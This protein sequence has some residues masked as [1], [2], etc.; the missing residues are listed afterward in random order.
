MATAR[1][2]AADVNWLALIRLLRLR[3]Q[4]GE[5]WPAIWAALIGDGTTALG[6]LAADAGDQPATLMALLALGLGCAGSNALAVAGRRSATGRCWVAG[7]PHLMLTLPSPWLAAAYRSPSYNVAGLMIPGIP[8]MAIGRNRHLAWGGT[9]LMAKSSEL[10]D[11]SAVPPDAVTVRRV[12]LQVRWS[13]PHDIVLRDTHY[14]PIV[15]DVPFAGNG[16]AVSALRWIGH[17]P[18]DEIS[19]MLALN[20]AS[21]MAALRRAAEKI[22]VPGQNLVFADRSGRVGHLRAAWLPHRAPGRVAA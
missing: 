19:A 2:A 21:D 8:L 15:S 20:R 4:S 17:E 10:F 3:R 1:L 18:S 7:D 6:R 12:R 11:V 5:D 22:A 9:N 13:R 16:P 14:G